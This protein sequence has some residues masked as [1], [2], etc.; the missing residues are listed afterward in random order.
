MTWSHHGFPV[1]LKPARVSVMKVELIRTYHTGGA[2]SPIRLY[3][4]YRLSDGREFELKL[5]GMSQ[6]WDCQS[7]PQKTRLYGGYETEEQKQEII[8]LLKREFPDS[9][10][11]AE[12]E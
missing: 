3:N 9:P 2:S 4:V 1:S 7:Y 8:L 11:I 12:L 5:G 10:Y 6:T